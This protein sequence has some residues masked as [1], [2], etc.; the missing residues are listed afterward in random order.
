[1]K[2]V[3]KPL[4]PLSDRVQ[5][6]LLPGTIP[7]LTAENFGPSLKLYNAVSHRFA[8]RDQFH[9]GAGQ[10]LLGGFADRIRRDRIEASPVLLP[11][12]PDKSIFVL[13][14]KG[15][16]QEASARLQG[17]IKNSPALHDLLKAPD[18]MT[19]W[20]SAKTPEGRVVGGYDVDHHFMF[21]VGRPVV[22]DAKALFGV[23][24]NFGRYKARPERDPAFLSSHQRGVAVVQYPQQIEKARQHLMYYMQAGA[25]SADRQAYCLIDA[26]VARRD[27]A[28]MFGLKESGIKLLYHTDADKK[29]IL[30][31]A[32]D[33]I[34]RPEPPRP[35]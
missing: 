30:Q 31:T 24:E 34:K 16:K 14:P 23:P 7:A 5:W 18:L 9:Q 2:P 29:T 20:L 11:S 27:P 4:L 17:I 28:K 32:Q 12:Y 13:A 6:L 1:M 35:V 10:M 33:V 22:E 19:A 3:D 21:V 26:D 25:G 8:L 15:H